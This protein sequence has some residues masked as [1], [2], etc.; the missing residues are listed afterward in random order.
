MRNIEKTL[1]ELF[2]RKKKYSRMKDSQIR[3]VVK[4]AAGVARD[5]AKHPQAVVKV[6]SWVSSKSQMRSRAEYYSRDGDL[7][8]KNSEG[9]TIPKKDIEVIINHWG[10]LDRIHAKKN[11]KKSRIAAMITLSSEKGTTVADLNLAVQ[12]MADKK[13]FSNHE[14]IY[15]VHTD[16]D[17]PHAHI[18]LRAIG[19][20]NSRLRLNKPELRVLREE[21]SE[22]LREAGMKSTSSS[23]HSRGVW[24][25]N[26]KLSTRKLRDRT[27]SPTEGDNNKMARN[28]LA[29]QDYLTGVRGKV[30]KK[31]LKLAKILRGLGDPA[32]NRFAELVENYAELPPVK[33][34]KDYLKKELA[35]SLS[36]SAS[37]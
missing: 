5:I 27:G 33:Q 14:F 1:E 13:T 34:Q 19:K 8:F 32:I 6:S 2:K 37:R 31:H 4:L 30:I 12:R 24:R 35:E 26:T 3:G 25:E 9:E 22:S 28:G 21:W 29:Q 15:V 36:T 20:D 23:R 7:D 18:M 16:T 10:Y 11:P 17:N